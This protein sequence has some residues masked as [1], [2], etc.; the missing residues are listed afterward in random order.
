M[1][2]LLC[3]DFLFLYNYF[4]FV[5]SLDDRKKKKNNNNKQAT[6]IIICETLSVEKELNVFIFLLLG[7]I[8]H[9]DI[10][11]SLLTSTSTKMSELH[12]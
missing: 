11:S 6:R 1:C 12:I 2:I 7:D 3:L 8:L 4:L 5:N 10:Y 9:T